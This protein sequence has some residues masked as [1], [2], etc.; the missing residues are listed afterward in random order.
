TIIPDPSVPPVPHNIS[1]DL[2]Q[3]VI[4]LPNSRN[5]ASAYS[6]LTTVLN[7][8]PVQDFEKTFARKLD[9]TQ[10]FYNPQVGT[11]SLSQPLQTDEVLGV[12]YQY[13]YNGRVFQVGEFSQD[14]PPDS[15]SSTQKVLYLKLLKATSQRTSLPIWDLMMKNVY[16]IGYGTLTPSDF[17]LDVL[18]QQPGLGAKRYFPFGDKNLGA[19]I[20]SLINLDRLNSQNDPQPDGVFDYVEGATVISPYSRVIFPVLEPFGRDLAAQV[21]NVV[22]PTA[23]DTLFYALY[24][25]IKAVAQ[26][27]PYL[28][29]FLLK[30]IAKT[31]GSSDISIGYNIPPGSVTVTA[32]GRTLQEGIDYDIN[33]DLGTIK[34]TNQAITNAGLPV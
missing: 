13:T 28:N 15:T 30:G 7:L 25:S 4:S 1:N 23:K 9:S 6:N 26:Q 21:Y 12:A 10:Y 16:T 34:I 31:S 32:G 33:Y 20:L 11:L 19:P 17:K 3:R 18:Y 8:K 22:P 27:Y 2:Y 24:D 14:V 5:P 29:R